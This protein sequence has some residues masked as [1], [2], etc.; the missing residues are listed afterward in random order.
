MSHVEL[1]PLRLNAKSGSW[2][3]LDKNFVSDSHEWELTKKS[4]FERD[5]YCCCF[6]NFK[7]RRYQEVY[8][9]DDNHENDELSNLATACSF[10]HQI[11]HIGLAALTNSG[12]LAWIPELSQDEVNH[13]LRVKFIVDYWLANKMN[14]TQQISAKDYVR[15][16]QSL[17]INL[18]ARSQMVKTVVGTDSALV[19]GDALI[20]TA[21]DI[22]VQERDT[23]LAGLRLV[24]TGTMF[25]GDADL[26]PKM[27]AFWTDKTGPFANNNMPHNWIGLLN[28]YADQL[29]ILSGDM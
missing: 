27:L 29:D 5:D 3:L 26:M 2:R 28:Q 23:A 25:R 6:C 22:G 15:A 4:V 11:Q 16:S 24:P 19:L 1:I 7:S 21:N 14:G 13:L 9:L 8:H 20:A 12:Y 18:K 17:D 10:C